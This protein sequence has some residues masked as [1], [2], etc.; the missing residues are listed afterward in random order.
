[1]PRP[2]LGLFGPQPL[3]QWSDE[4]VRFFP[5]WRN[6]VEGLGW[7]VS[8]VLS[9]SLNFLWVFKKIKKIVEHF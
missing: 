7:V 8:L 6:F 4:C 3:R 2:L 9:V 1:M 5:G